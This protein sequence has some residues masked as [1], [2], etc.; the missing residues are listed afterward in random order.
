MTGNYDAFLLGKDDGLKHASA[1]SMRSG[2]HGGANSKLS[3]KWIKITQY[4][5]CPTALL[6]EDG[7][8]FEHAH[9]YMHKSML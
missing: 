8:S 9:D 7:R 1:Y 5:T 2:G 6:D 3:L 4:V